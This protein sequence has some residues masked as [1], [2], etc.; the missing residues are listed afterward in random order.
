MGSAGQSCSS[1]QSMLQ[2]PDSSIP[3]K[4]RGIQADLPK[5]IP[6]GQQKGPPV[7][8]GEDIRYKDWLYRARLAMG[9]TQ[10]PKFHTN[11][12]MLKFGSYICMFKVLG[13]VLELTWQLYSCDSHCTAIL[14]QRKIYSSVVTILTNTRISNTTNQKDQRQIKTVVSLRNIVPSNSSDNLHSSISITTYLMGLHKIK[15]LMSISK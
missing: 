14:R 10:N 15:F 13:T 2:V 7:F 11:V 5:Q 6:K 3:T 9:S 1:F 8:R 4:P 12:L